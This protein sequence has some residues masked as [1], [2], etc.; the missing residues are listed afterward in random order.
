MKKL[1]IKILLSLFTLHS[2]GQVER[3]TL[4]EPTT[5]YSDID[6]EEEDDD[7]DEYYQKT[8]NVLPYIEDKSASIKLIKFQDNYKNKYKSD[9]EFNYAE[10]HKKDSAWTRFKKWLSRKIDEFFRQFDVNHTTSRNIDDMYRYISFFVILLFLYY[11]IRAYVVKDAYWLFK[12]KARTIDIPVDDIELN[13]ATVHFPTLIDKTVDEQHYRL[14]IRYYYLWLLQRLQEQNEI[15]WHIEK[16]NSDY[17]N[18]IKS[19]ELKEEFKYL[20]YIYNNIWYGEFEI[21]ESEFKQAQKS[22]DA[23]LKRSI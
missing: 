9:G 4:S 16:T 23:I 13:L 12:K 20:S 8:I 3:D 14:S 10:N 2:F 21:T 17:Y 6:I 18:E 11:I 1:Y 15:V 19:S 5:D 7:Y 22:F